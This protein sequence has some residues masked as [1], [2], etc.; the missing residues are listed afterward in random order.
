M[1]SSYS[2]DLKLELMVTGENSGT[3]GDKTNTNLN[4]LQQAIAG[5]QSVALTSTNTTL[6][7]T[8]ATIS[9]ARNAIL[10][11]TGTITA[12]CTVF[13]ET[14][15][16]KTYIVDNAT[17]GAF[18]VALNQVGGSSVIW[19]AADKGHKIIYLDGTNPNDVGNDL[20]TIRL[21]NQN[22]IR[23][24]D[25]DNS[26]YVSLKAGATIASNISFTLPNAL[27]TIE[28]AVTL[29]TTSGVQSFTAYSLPTADG[30]T[31]QVLQTNGS[32]TVTFATV[33]GGAAWQAVQTTN[34]NVTAK[35]GYFV[36]TSS[37][38]TAITATLPSSPTLGDFVSFIDYAGTFDSYNFIIARNGKNIQGVAEDLTVSVERAGLTLVYVDTTQG[39]LLQNK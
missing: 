8:N 38:S 24:G 13:I 6:S 39:W 30:A 34:F 31:N 20:S 14:G 15:I 25:S 16:E 12:N 22:E 37:N 5:Y 1:P 9:D 26:N 2:T 7:M 23:F 27:P 35:E 36:N 4:L 28:N 21:P 19:G 11:F 18:T 29:T 17:S 3:W 33:S 10:Q 32:G